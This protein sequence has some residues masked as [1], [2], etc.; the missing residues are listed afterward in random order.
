M[1][2]LGQDGP[3]LGVLQPAEKLAQDAEAGWH[4]A[5]GVARVHALGQHPHRERTGH[6]AAQG[7]GQPHPLVV[8]A[9][10]IQADHERGVAESLSQGVDIERQVGAARLLAGLDQDHRAGVRHAGV[11]QSQQGG[12]RPKHGVTVIGAAAA[13]ELVTLDH[14]LPG[15]QPLGPAGHLRLLVQVAV[16]QHA[17]GTLARNVDQNHGGPA[18]QPDHLEGGALQRLDL[19]A[20]PSH[21]QVH[22][23]VHVAVRGP[24][25][26]EGGTLVGDADVVHQRRNDLG[27]PEP[28]DEA[29]E[30]GDVGARGIGHGPALLGCMVL[31]VPRADQNPSS[32]APRGPPKLITRECS[33]ARRHAGPDR[34]RH[35]R[36]GVPDPRQSA[37]GGGDRGPGG[38]PRGRSRAGAGDRGAR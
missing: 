10:G 18:L 20:G 35:P 27:V 9:A 26:I 37:P 5:G 38:V 21:E 33:E 4:D 15:P 3:G 1:Q 13:I 8:A 23:L 11:A 16:E 6:E 7:G 22:S 30:A 32:P 34:P 2:G 24:I 31:G 25:G 17:V 28:V 14:R 19:A 29:G 36:G 12:D